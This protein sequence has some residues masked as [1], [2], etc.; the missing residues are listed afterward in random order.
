MFLKRLL[1]FATVWVLITISGNPF[2]IDVFAQQQDQVQVTVTSTNDALIYIDGAIKGTS[3]WTGKISVGK[4]KIRVEKEN[5]FSREYEILTVRGRDL[6]IDLMLTPKTGTIDIVTDPDQAMITVNGR[7]YGFSPRTI[8]ELPYG[9]YVVVVEKPEHSRVVRKVNINDVKPVSLNLSLYSGKEVTLNTSPEGANV[10]LD[11]ELL[12]VTPLKIWLKYGTH[13]LKFEKDELSI[14]ENVVVSQSGKK[15][16]EYSLRVSNDPFENQMVFVKGGT[17]RMGD[18]FGDGNKEEKPVHQ[19]TLSDYYIGKYEVTQAQ[20][21]AIMGSNPSHFAGCDNCPVER[22]SWLDVQEFLSKVNELTGKSYR[23]PTEAEWEYAARGGQESRGFRY[24]GK[25]NIN[26]VAWYTGNSGNKTNPVGQMEPNELGIY[27]MSGNVWEWTFDWF[28]YYTDTPTPV[29]NP[30]G[31][32]KGDF[33]IVRGGSWYG[34]IGGSRVACRGSDDPSNKRS[35]I[36]FRVVLP[37]HG[38]K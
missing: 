24:A 9:E 26:F 13:L 36:G 15:T 2:G 30:M 32:D 1:F 7:M 27:D 21:V 34:Y 12:G 6:N 20:W 33:R 23:L 11:K 35:Y 4:H 19:V 17:F 10:F 5:Y 37:A 14:A 8:S 28:G 31:P 22:V 16:F 3:P 38:A 25:N 18:T 29:L